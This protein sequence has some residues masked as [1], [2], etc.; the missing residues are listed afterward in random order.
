MNEAHTLTN[1]TLLIKTK[2]RE[3]RVLIVHQN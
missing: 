1:K 3:D 2:Q